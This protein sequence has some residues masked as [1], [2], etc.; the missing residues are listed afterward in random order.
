MV[1]VCN[2]LVKMTDSVT[3]IIRVVD[4]FFELELWGSSP[5]HIY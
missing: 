3:I 4:F 2:L 5:Q 1:E